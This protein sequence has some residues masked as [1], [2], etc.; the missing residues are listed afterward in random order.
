MAATLYILVWMFALFQIK[1]YKN[2]NDRTLTDLEECE[3]NCKVHPRCGRDHERERK[4]GPSPCQG[5]FSRFRQQKIKKI[6]GNKRGMTR[7]EERLIR[8]GQIPSCVGLPEPAVPGGKAICFFESPSTGRPTKCPRGRSPIRAGNP[9]K[10]G[11]Q[12]A[13]G[14]WKLSAEGGE[15]V[16]RRF[17]ILSD[18]AAYRSALRPLTAMLSHPAKVAEFHRDVEKDLNRDFA[19]FNHFLAEGKVENPAHGLLSIMN[20]DITKGNLKLLLNT[21]GT[22]MVNVASMLPHAASEV[23]DPE[24]YTPAIM[25]SLNPITPLIRR[26]TT[27]EAD[28]ALKGGSTVRFAIAQEGNH[29][30]VTQ[31]HVMVDKHL[32]MTLKRG[33][34]PQRPVISSIRG[35]GT[36]TGERPREEV[37][38]ESAMKQPKFV[39]SSPIVATG[40]R[41]GETPGHGGGEVAHEEYDNDYYSQSNHM[42]P[43]KNKLLP[44][45]HSEHSDA[46]YVYGGAYDVGNDG[47]NNTLLWCVVVMAV[48]M[49]LCG[50]GALCIGIVLCGY[51][52]YLRNQDEGKRNRMMAND[53][54]MS[55]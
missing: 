30:Y 43:K 28:S 20:D 44:I 26:M 32:A 23:I 25:M 39:I 36:G 12:A 27:Q 53:I 4:S 37:T 52:L 46:G 54:Q 18:E 9:R 35:T 31:Q 34:M 22:N 51:A 3:T 40:T 7:E 10:T 1:A 16:I 5:Q 21:A 38:H 14:D 48:L 45:A 11:L 55:Q 41:P 29:E 49:V 6:C 50:C 24:E 15:I 42:D 19:E 8:A 2:C 47:S 33:E 17:C 13:T